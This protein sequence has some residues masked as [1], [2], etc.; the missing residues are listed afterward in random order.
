VKAPGACGAKLGGKNVALEILELHHHA[1]LVPLDLVEKTGTFYEEVLGLA[2]DV[3][4]SNIP[5]LPGYFLD[6]PN[7]TQIHLLGGDG[8]TPSHYATAPGQDPVS[9]HVALAVADVR[10]AEEELIRLRVPYWI[11]D[12]VASPELKQLF[13]RDPAGNVIELHQI[14]RCRCKASDRNFADSKRKAAT[15]SK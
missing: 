8:T 12:N 4:R 10:K 6:L 7:D 5:H 2:K 13:F 11:L 1:V 14:G 3:G 15:P 9:H